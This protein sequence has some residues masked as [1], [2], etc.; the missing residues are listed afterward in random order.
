M[1]TS[2]SPPSMLMR[3]FAGQL[4]THP[5]RCTGCR[6]FQYRSSLNLYRISTVMRT[7]ILQTKSGR[8]GHGWTL[9]P[10]RVTGLHPGHRPGGLFRTAH[11]RWLGDV[12]HLAAPVLRHGENVLTGVASV[13]VGDGNL[14]GGF[15][16]SRG[17]IAAIRARV[18]RHW[19]AS[20]APILNPSPRTGNT[21]KSMKATGRSAAIRTLDHDQDRPPKVDPL[22]L[23]AVGASPLLRLVGGILRA[24]EGGQ[25]PTAG[26]TVNRDGHRVWHWG[27]TSLHRPSARRAGTRLGKR[28]QRT[29]RYT[30][31]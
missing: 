1:A 29:T 28:A 6:D 8:D 4:R 24:A 9:E 17:T 18:G 15:K 20:R 19:G 12:M 16:P 2:V 7:G 21:R 10:S 11:V 27:A 23:V 25:V 5:R 13:V 22:Q 30:G 14:A 26:G 31:K 3:R